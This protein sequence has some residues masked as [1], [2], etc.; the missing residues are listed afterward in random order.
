M[1][2]GTNKN[3]LNGI[4]LLIKINFHIKISL[5]CFKPGAVIQSKGIIESVTKLLYIACVLS[6]IAWCSSD[7]IK[8]FFLGLLD[9]NQVFFAA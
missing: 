2:Q 8:P 4:R 9:L 3:E 5:E 7:Q 6:N 1:F